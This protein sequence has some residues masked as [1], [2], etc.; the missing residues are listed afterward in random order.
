SPAKVSMPLARSLTIE[1]AVSPVAISAGRP[2]PLASGSA[3][4]LPPERATVFVSAR[5]RDAKDGAGAAVFRV[6]AAEI[7][8]PAA[9]ASG[10]M[11]KVD[12]SPDGRWLLVPSAGGDGSLRIVSAPA[13]ARPGQPRSVDLRGNA[14]GNGGPESLRPAALRVQP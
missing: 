2:L 10:V 3:I 7:A 6:G 13:D 8:T 5:R 4:R 14:G 9:T 12:M 1:E 11:G